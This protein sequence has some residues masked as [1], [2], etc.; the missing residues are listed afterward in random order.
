M[1]AFCHKC[2]SA[3]WICPIWIEKRDSSIYAYSIQTCISIYICVSTCEHMYVNI[4][5]TIHIYINVFCLHIYIYMIQI[6]YIHKSLQNV[7]NE[8]YLH[9]TTGYTLATWCEELTHW[10]RP[11]C[12]EGLKAGGE[13]DDRMK[14]LDGIMDSMGMSL[15]KLREL[16]SDREAWHAAVHGVVK[17]QTRLS[18]WTELSYCLCDF[19][20]VS[21]EKS[22][23]GL[24]FSPRYSSYP[25]FSMGK[26]LFLWLLSRFFSWSLIFYSF[27]M[28]FLDT[29][30]LVFILVGILLSFLEL[31][32]DVFH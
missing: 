21:L 8:K 3:H 16:V 11:W 1:T 20:K 17:S 13:G 10:K 12:W 9:D 15:S 32:F 18:N 2:S 22:D 24:F 27:N 30:F 25:W 14:W 5:E 26:V 4:C 6:E 19:R 23:V 29:D 31:W 7:D 28:K